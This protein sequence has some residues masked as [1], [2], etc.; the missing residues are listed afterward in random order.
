MTHCRTVHGAL[1]SRAPHVGSELLLVLWSVVAVGC[2]GDATTRP[3]PIPDPVPTAQPAPVVPDGL[4][5]GM[6]AQLSERLE[7]DHFI[8]YRRPG[9][10][11][12]VERQEAYHRWAV[13]YLGVTPPEKISFFKFQ[14]LEDMEAAVGRPKA[15]R[16][17][18]SD[19]ALVAIHSWNNHEAFHIYNGLLCEPPT[20]RLYEEGMVVAHEFDPLNDSWESE[21]NRR[22][23]DEPVIYADLV[24]EYRREG[25]L[26]P[27]D[28][29][30]ESQSFNDS[31]QVGTLMI[32]TEAG[33]F[34]SYLIDTFGLDRMKQAFCS[35]AYEDTQETIQQ[36]FEEIFGLS[37]QRVEQD[38][39]AY[40]DASM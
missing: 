32:Y 21:W 28:G 30:L 40:L 18:P 8:F 25:R 11:I 36:R 3:S 10:S 24:R 12:W 39:L 13:D 5:P 37:V 2:S 9:D 26:F 20:I 14:S 7:S 31:S 15:G 23:L 38:W 34:V 19:L 6:V 22:E 16:A 17:F 27:I 4:D 33:M 29:I 1:F 35:V